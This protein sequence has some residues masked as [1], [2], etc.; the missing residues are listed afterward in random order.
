MIFENQKNSFTT[1]IS[2][3]YRIISALI[4]QGIN[5]TSVMALEKP[6]NPP[7]NWEIDIEKFVQEINLMIA[8]LENINLFKYVESWNQSIMSLTSNSIAIE[9]CVLLYQRWK[10]LGKP[11]RSSGQISVFNTD[12]VTLFDRLVYEY[13]IRLWTGSGDS[14]VAA[15]LKDNT[16][17]RFVKISEE[18]WK[19]FIN[20]I[21]SGQYK[22]KPTSSKTLK[23]FLYY[24]YFL[25][26]L[27]PT[28]KNQATVYDI[29]HLVAQS[30]FRDYP[31][32]DQTLKDN[33]LN[34]SILPK[35]E[36]IEKTDKKLNEIHDAWLIDQIKKYA[37]I[38]DEDINTLSDLSNV[39]Q[40]KKRKTSFI[41]TY[42]IE[43]NNMF[44][45]IN[46]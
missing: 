46:D 14:M 4:V 26:R 27:Q 39:D 5:N 35:G 38:T 24:G 15:H 29:D 10:C 16:G 25:R 2:L 31:A 8:Q 42:T 43:R 23:P 21:E 11:T 13:S 1:S 7:I 45:T 41:N 18:E 20:E 28:L 33:F 17:S 32:L 12:A 3:S 30:F 22:G 36:N 40:L 37:Q 44:L 19:N 9:F 6:Q 34:F